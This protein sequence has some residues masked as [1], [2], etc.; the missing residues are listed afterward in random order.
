M[1]PR[2]RR[3]AFQAGS[4]APARP[5]S[6]RCRAG[7]RRAARP[8]AITAPPPYC[9]PLTNATRSARA[10]EAADRRR[11]SIQL[12]RAVAHVAPE[13]EPHVGEDAA[14]A[15]RAGRARGS[16]APTAA[17][18]P[19]PA[20]LRKGRSLIIPTSIAPRHG[21]PRAPPARASG[22][23]RDAQRAGEAVARA[24]GHEAERG[25]GPEQAPGD[26]VGG[27]VAADGEH[28][29]RA[30][31]RRLRR[32][33]ARASPGAVVTRT[34]IAAP[35]RPAAARAAARARCAARPARGFRM[36]TAFTA[37]LGVDARASRR[38]CGRR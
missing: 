34:S 8:G 20:T 31:R 1:P 28:E 27:A 37:A 19:A 26:L 32:A 10:L 15:A 29:L 3:G 13:A 2:N 30:R 18:K 17:S 9:R 7:R 11:S 14:P 21:R 5:R 22:P 38:P 24:H 4:R 36:A 23:Q 25:A 16:P 6:R 12:A 33:S 35:A